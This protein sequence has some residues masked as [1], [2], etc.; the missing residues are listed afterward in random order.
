MR[1]EEP[2]RASPRERT[3]FGSRQGA[4]NQPSG[5]YFSDTVFLRFSP[6]SGLSPVMRAF[7]IS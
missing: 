3:E 2:A 7:A 4:Y 5:V 6:R 1:P